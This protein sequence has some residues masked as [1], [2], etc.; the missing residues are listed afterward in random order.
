MTSSPDDL[1]PEQQA[2]LASLPSWMT[3]PVPELDPEL[4]PYLDE[5]GEYSRM[6][7][8]MIK[9]P[10][11][12]A[13][14]YTPGMNGRYN[15]QLAWKKDCLVK[16]RAERNW[17]GYINAHER[18]Y[19]MDAFRDIEDEMTDAEY[20]ENLAWM[21]RDSE[22]IREQPDEWEELITSD[23]PERERI[24]EDDE[25]AALAAMPD[26][27]TIYQ[28]HTEE[29]DD[30]WSWTID[31]KI[32]VWFARRFAAME[33]S[34]PMITTAYVEREFVLAY[35]TQRGEDEILVDPEY[36]YGHETR[37]VTEHDIDKN[38]SAS[39]TWSTNMDPAVTTASN[40]IIQMNGTK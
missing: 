32:A 18:P 36:V 14:P 3:D 35:F 26:T 40:A 1:T 8:P 29:R 11:V 5:T 17:S 21:W 37:E 12:F 23:R 13:I 16:Y 2:V 28:G 27:I 39:V 15:A 20:W 25:R 24:M 9:H 7:W 10:L 31:H 22:N 38:G 30:G 33:E 34:V 6:G 4:V 19:R